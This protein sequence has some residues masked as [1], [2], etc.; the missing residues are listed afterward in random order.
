[1]HPC[2]LTKR[3]SEPLEEISGGNKGDASGSELDVPV[4]SYFGSLLPAPV[5]LVGSFD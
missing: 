5:Y 4:V 2:A 3:L 1:L